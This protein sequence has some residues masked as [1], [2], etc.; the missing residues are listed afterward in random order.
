MTIPGDT[1]DNSP[2]DKGGGSGGVVIIIVAVVLILGITFAACWICSR[3]PTG[4][5]TVIEAEERAT[6]DTLQS[7]Q[8]PMPVARSESAANAPTANAVPAPVDPS[9]AVL[10]MQQQTMA[11]QNL[12]QQQTMMQQLHM[13]HMEREAHQ[14]RA[15]R[16][17]SQERGD[18]QASLER[19][20]I[21]AAQATHSEASLAMQRNRIPT[22]Q[23]NGQR[24][25]PLDTTGD[26]KV[27]SVLA[28]TNGDGNLD[29]IIALD[30]S[31]QQAQPKEDDSRSASSPTAPGES[32][33]SMLTV[34]QLRG[35]QNVCHN[36]MRVCFMVLL[37]TFSV[38]LTTAV[39]PNP[40]L[41]C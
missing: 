13:Q 5:V 17:A 21:H 1:M 6:F 9:A 11:Q 32:K 39:M 3:S 7:K 37:S 38:F 4:K 19:T 23:A 12:I 28:D 24:A 20:H 33:L 10:L 36:C 18:R 27:D 41:S 25:V 15:E 2:A 22:A 26:G 8:S 40:A 16:A 31:K 35:A 34:K 30:H 14:E 29:T